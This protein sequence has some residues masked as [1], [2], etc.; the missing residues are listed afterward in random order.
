MRLAPEYM[1]VRALQWCENLNSD[2][3]I[4]RQDF[5]RANSGVD[6]KKKRRRRK[7][8]SCQCKSTSLIR[9]TT[10]P[11]GYEAS[12]VEAQTDILDTWATSSI[13]PQ[14]SAKGISQDM[15]LTKKDI[16]NFF[17]PIY[18]RKPMKLLELGRFI[19]L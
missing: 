8:F 4:S 9:K 19:R 14:I 17:L 5:W 3:C 13:S 7:I 2:W 6:F 12:E 15:I 16:Q 10:L 11:E 18:A 1:K